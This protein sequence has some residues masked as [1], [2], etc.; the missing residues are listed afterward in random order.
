MDLETMD[1][2]WGI[3]AEIVG[4]VRGNLILSISL[5]NVG[6]TSSQAGQDMKVL[7]GKMQF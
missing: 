3:G 7:V 5:F 6:S 1:F 4:A 2:S